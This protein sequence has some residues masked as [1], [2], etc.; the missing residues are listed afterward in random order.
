MRSPIH[1]HP[2]TVTRWNDSGARVIAVTSGKGG[3]GKSNVV[4]NLAVELTRLGYRVAIFDA[5]LGMANAEVLLGMVP[6]CTLYDFLFNGRTMEEI[7]T[8]SPQGIQVIS[9]GSGFVEL[10]NLDPGSSKRLGQGLQQLDQQFDFILVDTGAGIS[11][12]VLGFVAAADEVIVVVTPEPTSMTDSY[13]LIKVLSKYKVHQDIKVVVN[14]ATDVEEA[15]RTYEQLEYT[16]S[17]FLQVGL[18]NLGYIPEDYHVVKAVK[19][20]QPFTIMAPSATA[21]QSLTRIASRLA[22][23]KEIKPTG[24]QGFFGKLI[25]LFG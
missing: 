8:R 16:C 25:R 24:L 21:S 3:V 17:R 6:T 1:N 5:D 13:G 18:I 9:G 11:K 23:G 4:V 7:M 2:G 14:R 15:Q 10:A 20:Q 12:A 22:T 19:N